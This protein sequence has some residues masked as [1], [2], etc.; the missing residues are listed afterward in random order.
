MAKSQ[1]LP[2]TIHHHDYIVWNELCCINW[3][4]AAQGD[5]PDGGSTGVQVH[6]L[7][8]LS[9]ITKG[10]WTPISLIGWNTSKL[11]RVARSSL[12]AEIQSMGIGEDESYLVRL[13]WSEINGANGDN[14]DEVVNQTPCVLVTDRKSHV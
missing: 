8:D 4:D 11:P 10:D 9:K 2:I 3:N 12:A 6:G 13:M 5:R 1:D 14:V 7:A